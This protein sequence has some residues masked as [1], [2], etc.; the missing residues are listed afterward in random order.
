MTAA[1]RASI[2]VKA[3][4]SHR[5]YRDDHGTATAFCRLVAIEHELFRLAAGVD[6]IELR[7]APGSGWIPTAMTTLIIEAL[8]SVGLYADSADPRAERIAR[9]TRRRL[10]DALARIRVRCNRRLLVGTTRI[11]D[12]DGDKSVL[13]LVLARKGIHS[14]EWKLAA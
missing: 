6:R 1:M 11:F 8:R 9:D 13:V 5:V 10:T 2:P 3:G 14:C 4:I 12:E 7:Q